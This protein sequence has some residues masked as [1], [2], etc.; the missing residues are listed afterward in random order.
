MFERKRDKLFVALA[1][2]LAW[3]PANAFADRYHVKFSTARADDDEALRL[4]QVSAL[5]TPHRGRVQLVR[6]AEDSGLYN[7]WAGF[8]TSIEAVDEHGR[9]LELVIESPGVWRLPQHKRGEIEIRYSVNLQHDR[10]PND[11]GDDEL[12]YARPYGLM[13][14]SRA[15]FIEGAPSDDVA[16][17][18]EL[19]DGWKASTQWQPSDENEWRFQPKNTDDLLN[20]AFMVGAHQQTTV[21]IGAAKALI[22][23]GPPVVKMEAVFTPLLQGFL[24]SYATLLQDTLTDNFLLIGGDASFLGGG[25]M[26]R[27]ISLSLNEDAAGQG[28]QL[29]AAY[30]IAHE[31]FHLWNSKW[32]IQK[33]SADDLEWFQEG[34]A[35]YY[36]FLTSLRMG[37]IDEPTYWGFVAE[38]YTAYAAAF[39]AGDSLTSAAATKNTSATSYDLIYSGGMIALL[40]MDIEVRTAT[41]SEKSLD[42]IVREVHAKYSTGRE[43]LTLEELRKLIRVET[44][45]DFIR[46]MRRNIRGSE[47]FD[48]KEALGKLGLNLAHQYTEQGLIVTITEL[49]MQSSENTAARLDYIT[50]Q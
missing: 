22:A 16:V 46:L 5:L 40:M 31:G 48:L 4:A 9:S 15:L 1:V 11:P 44:G 18:F 23:L 17:E 50:G 42:D 20:S 39:E 24:G 28:A 6:A 25:V 34:L 13:W 38:R 47:Q 10:F 30:I 26:G 7:G 12:A 49:P 32:R 36:A 8:V 37:L 41:N 29:L 27:T 2:L 19:P 45:V 43:T 35:E 14:S 3:I 33:V 21:D